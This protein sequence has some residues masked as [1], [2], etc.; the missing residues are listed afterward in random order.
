MSTEQVGS[1]KQ[2]A[3][4]YTLVLYRIKVTVNL[5]LGKTDVF[6]HSIYTVSAQETISFSKQTSILLAFVEY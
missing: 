2:L 4:I 6:L 5:G 3:V 1:S